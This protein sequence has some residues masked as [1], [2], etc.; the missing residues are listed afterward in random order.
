MSLKPFEKEL[1]LML[2]MQRLNPSHKKK[3]ELEHHEKEKEREK[4]REKQ[5]RRNQAESAE[6]S[7]DFRKKVAAAVTA[8]ADTGAAVTTGGMVIEN[9][10]P[11]PIS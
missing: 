11:L 1:D 9:T 10:Y 6:K 4:E 2:A 7:A 3:L 8:N 5:E